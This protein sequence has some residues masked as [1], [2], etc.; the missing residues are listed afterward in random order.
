VRIFVV[1][2]GKTVS[3]LFFSYRTSPVSTFIRRTEDGFTTAV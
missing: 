3:V 1:L 2:A